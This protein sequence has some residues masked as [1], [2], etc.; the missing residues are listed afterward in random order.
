MTS[1]LLMVPSSGILGSVSPDLQCTWQALVNGQYVPLFAVTPCQ[2]ASHAHESF[3]EYLNQRVK[4]S[5][6]GVFKSYTFYL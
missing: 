2:A 3:R 6:L 4:A 5:V 1:L